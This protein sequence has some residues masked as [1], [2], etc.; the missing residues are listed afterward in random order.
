MPDERVSP[1]AKL[2]EQ[3]RGSRERQHGTMVRATKALQH[4]SELLRL[5]WPDTFLGRQH[6]EFVPLPEDVMRDRPKRRPR[7]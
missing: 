3:L 1:P 7:P 5:S 4:G 6:Y 2:I